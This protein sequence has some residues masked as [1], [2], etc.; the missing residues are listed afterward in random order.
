VLERIAWVD[1]MQTLQFD[2]STYFTTMRPDPDSILG[3]RF[4]TGD[5]KNYSG[6][7][8]PM[9]DQLLAKGRSTY[10]EAERATAYKDVQTRIYETAWYGTIW[11]RK[12]FDAA[13]K[14]LK[15]R[16]PTQEPDWGLHTAWIDK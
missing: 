2:L 6:M 10:D 5:G 9:L 4:E 8:D 14:T 15:G 11:Y 12:Y 16:E 7:S 13:K 3:G 1:K